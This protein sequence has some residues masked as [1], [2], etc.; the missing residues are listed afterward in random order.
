MRSAP[1]CS[2]RS[3]RWR[4]NCSSAR[5]AALVP[6]PPRLDPLADP[7]FFLG[8][9]LVE[10]GGLG[11]FDR[12]DRLFARGEGVEI[13]HPVDQ[14]AAV[15]LDDPRGQLAEEDAVVRH[16]D[17]RAAIAQQIILQPGDGVDV[18][19]V[20]RLVQEH[21]VGVAHQAAR[22][23][24]APLEPGGEAL[25]IGRGV[26]THARDDR[27]HLQTPAPGVLIAAGWRAGLGRGQAAGQDVGHAARQSFGHFLDQVGHSQAPFADHSP[28]VGFQLAGDDLEQ[29]GFA[30]AVAPDEAQPLAALDLQ[31]DILQDE[32]A[33]ETDADVP[34]TQQSHENH[35][36]AGVR[37]KRPVSN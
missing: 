18:Q 26:E 16:E 35:L 21:D 17:Q 33:A 13:T 34:H 9:L 7:G 31:T 24:D 4:R 25:E 37:L 15:D 10:F 22:Q 23:E 29:R 2:R 5:D 32:R 1:G 28:R 27:V 36:G 6:R 14:A 19:V 8:Q 30:H 12:Q 11:G 3:R 20:G